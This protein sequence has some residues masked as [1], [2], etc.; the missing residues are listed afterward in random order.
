MTPRTKYEFQV[1][2]ENEFGD[3]MYSAIIEAQTKGKYFDN[4]KKCKKTVSHT[5]SIIEVSPLSA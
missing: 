1:I 2:G 5:I 3:G 4:K